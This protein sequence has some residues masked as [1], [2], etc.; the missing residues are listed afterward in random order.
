MSE[1]KGINEVSAPIDDF[2]AGDFPVVHLG[3][4]IVSGEGVLVKGT[5]LGKITANGKL[6]A[7][8]NGASN[9]TETAKY[10]LAE[11]VDAT[12]EDAAA[13]VWATGEF[14]ESKLTGIDAAGIADLEAVN[15]YVK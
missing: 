6:A 9:G 12:A 4:T 13:V 7:Y 1:S 15:I 8:D 14:K 2:K 10:I 5:V 11:K 3:K